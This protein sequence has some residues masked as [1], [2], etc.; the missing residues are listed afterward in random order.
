MTTVLNTQLT[1]FSFL[2]D[3][4]P[5]FAT[6]LIVLVKFIAEDWLFIADRK[7]RCEIWMYVKN[8]K[9]F[10]D[11]K[12]QLSLSN[13][14]CLQDCFFGKCKRTGK[15]FIVA[16]QDQ[17]NVLYIWDIETKYPYETTY[18]FPNSNNISLYQVKDQFYVKMITNNSKKIYPIEF[19]S[20]GKQ[21]NFTKSDEIK[22]SEIVQM[23]KHQKPTSYSI[24]D[25]VW[26]KRVKIETTLFNLNSAP[27]NNLRIRTKTYYFDGTDKSLE[28]A[29]IWCYCFG[30]VFVLGHDGFVSV[31]IQ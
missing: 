7:G 16:Y 3:F 22:D 1:P 25:V 10:V 17:S 13:E 18:E 31:W 11:T 21:F 2:Q 27:K 8:L 24:S 29:S 5:S 26:N 20:D 4:V 12:K 19:F 9:K 30:S 6:D 15:Q 14:R 28:L 23:L